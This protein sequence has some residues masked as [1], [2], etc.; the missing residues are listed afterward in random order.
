MSGSEVARRLRSQPGTAD[1][2]IL[3]MTGVE[4]QDRSGADGVLR[5]PFTPAGLRSLVAAWLA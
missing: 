2:P 4:T 5:K 1:V 3:L